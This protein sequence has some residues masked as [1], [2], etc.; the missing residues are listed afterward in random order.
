VIGTIFYVMDCVH[1]RIFRDANLPGATPAERRAIY[2]S[3]S[4]VLARLHLVDWRAVGL[5]D[6]GRPGDYYAR[7]IHRWGQQYRASETEKI[8]A[9]ERLMEWLP[10]HIPGSGGPTLGPGGDRP[11]HTLVAP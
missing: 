2:E 4:D 11:G 10:E 5:A 7:Q 6:F 1:G 8:E 3:M 9:M